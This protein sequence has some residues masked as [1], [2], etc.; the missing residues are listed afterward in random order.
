MH[1]GS[2]CDTNGV[3]LHPGTPPPPRLLPETPWDPYANGV[4]F[5]TADFLYRRVEMSA[6]AIDEL[7]DLWAESMED[8]VPP[9]LLTHTSTFMKPLMPRNTVMLHGIA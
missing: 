8:S 2:P 7:L 1:K 4:Q 5:K 3:P 6:G 9:P